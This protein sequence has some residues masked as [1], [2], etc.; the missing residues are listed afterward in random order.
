MLAQ[1]RVRRHGAP[2]ALRCCDQAGQARLSNRQ[3]H[4]SPRHPTK[5]TLSP[6]V[7]LGNRRGL[8][9]ARAS[10][11]SRAGCPLCATP[12][13]VTAVYVRPCFAAA[14]TRV[15]ALCICTRGNSVATATA[16]E[17]RP[18]A[19]RLSH[20]RHRVAPVAWGLCRS[21]PRSPVY[22]DATKC[23]AV[24]PA[25]AV[26]WHAR[27]GVGPLDLRWLRARDPGTSAATS[28]WLRDGSPRS[29]AQDLSARLEKMITHM[30]T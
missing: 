10:P 7:R 1:A 21:A 12:V 16:R 30:D 11:A 19:T 29:A 5:P 8:C 22:L 15:C 9:S 3:G 18:N 24:A 23:A 13:F 26:D 14:T 6:Q 27:Q 4:Y 25:T 20:T 2:C 17:A 28:S